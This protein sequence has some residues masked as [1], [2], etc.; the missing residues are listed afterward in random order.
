VTSAWFYGNLVNAKEGYIPPDAT[1]DNHLDL[2]DAYC[3]HLVD[4]GMKVSMNVEGKTFKAWLSKSSW[5]GT[6]DAKTR[7]SLTNFQGWFINSN[8]NGPDQLAKGW[9]GLTSQK[10]LDS[11]IMYSEEGEKIAGI[12]R[13]WTGTE[14]SG[15]ASGTDC[16]GWTQRWAQNGD[17]GDPESVTAWTFN[18]GLFWNCNSPARL[19]CV[20]VPR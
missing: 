20:E 13:V 1:Y 3:Q 8:N 14:S 6:E 4:E 7:L 10:K 5:S 19:Y 2:A 9:G 12:L 16:N 17:Y 18:N 15:E 11:K